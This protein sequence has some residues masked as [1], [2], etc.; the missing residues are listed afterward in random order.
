MEITMQV[1]NL[2][3][4]QS[5]KIA[6]VSL[7]ILMGTALNV[8]AF[9][10]EDNKLLQGI[11]YTPLLEEYNIVGVAL[12]SGKDAISYGIK[13]ATHSDISHVG[14]I[15]SDVDDENEWY[16]FESTGSKREVLSGI[17]PH[18]R[19]TPWNIVTGN[20]SPEQYKSYQET[21]NEKYYG[22]NGYTGQISYRLFE[23]E[24]KNRPDSVLVTNFVE[25]YNHRSY[26]R[27]PLRLIKA[28]FKK[29]KEPKSDT[30]R[31]VFC[32]ELTAKMLM[33][34]QLMPKDIPSNFTPKD[35]ASENNLSL[36]PGVTLTPEFIVEKESKRSLPRRTV[37]LI[38]ALFR[39]NK[40]SSNNDSDSDL[41]TLLLSDWQ[42]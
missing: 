21:F 25:D 33:E 34:I 17:Y 9:D 35:F 20:A 5:K 13:R 8:R 29:N 15:L 12:F 32:S 11:P 22:K 26:A 18:V 40:K 19:L 38:K 4:T 6:L 36:L 14:I 3:N 30:L 39:R 27:N 41:K 2:N 28:V 16:C 1:L 42:S 10:R 23:F 31:T 7:A 37:K 24:D